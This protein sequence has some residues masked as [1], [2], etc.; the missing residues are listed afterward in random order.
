MFHGKE[1][2][3]SGK[4]GQKISEKISFKRSK[5]K[6]KEGGGHRKGAGI[7]RLRLGERY[8]TKREGRAE[9]KSTER[10]IGHGS[11]AIE[12]WRGTLSLQSGNGGDRNGS[13][14][15]RGRK[16]PE[17]DEGDTGLKIRGQ[18]SVAAQGLGAAEA[19]KSF[20]SQGN[21]ED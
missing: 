3:Q 11:I 2:P 12:A 7:A 1:K 10:G 18:D 13:S 21:G 20:W 14:A 17:T 6:G 5:N 16:T 9:R 8:A 19:G 4:A 15:K